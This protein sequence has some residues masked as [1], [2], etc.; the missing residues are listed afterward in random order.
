MDTDGNRCRLTVA[1]NGKGIMQAADGGIGFRAL[2]D[3][4]K[5]IGGRLEKK[6]ADKG[7]YCTFCLTS[8]CII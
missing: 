1:D 3:R 7:T 6:E 8:M 4:V 5:T 2:D